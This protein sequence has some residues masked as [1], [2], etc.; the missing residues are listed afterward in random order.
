MRMLRH[1]DVI[2]ILDTTLDTTPYITVATLL[3]TR[4]LGTQGLEDA[5]LF[6][7]TRWLAAHFACI[8]DPRTMQA[9]SGTAAML[10][11]RGT[12]GEGLRETSY[13]QQVLVL[14]PTGILAQTIGMKRASIHVE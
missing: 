7:I 6:E 11:Q 13:G 10:F 3:V 2:A 1:V 14:D 8:R 4:H 9:R 5:L 12:A